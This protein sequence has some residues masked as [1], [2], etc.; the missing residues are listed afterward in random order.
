[1]IQEQN[2]GE[3]I[4]SHQGNNDNIYAFVIVQWFKET[5]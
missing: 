1:M 5:T 4:F 2:Y 3:A